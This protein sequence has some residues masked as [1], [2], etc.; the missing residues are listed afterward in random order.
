MVSQYLASKSR[1]FINEVV[2]Q[3]MLTKFRPN[4]HCCKE[5]IGCMSFTK[6]NFEQSTLCI[7]LILI[8]QNYLLI[9]SLLFPSILLF[10]FY[11]FFIN[12]ADDFQGPSGP[13]WLSMIMTRLMAEAELG[14][15]R[16]I[17]FWYGSILGWAGFGQCGQR[18]GLKNF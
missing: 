12:K 14:N 15:R 8:V 3:C 10:S 4:L 17:S 11:Y 6:M 16:N 7:F 5:S 18:L 13:Q 2:I 1:K 9:Y